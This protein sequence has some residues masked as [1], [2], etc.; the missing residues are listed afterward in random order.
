MKVKLLLQFLVFFSSFFMPYLLQAQ[1]D[2]TVIQAVSN[3]VSAN[4]NLTYTILVVN[5]GPASATNVNFTENLPPGTTFVSFTA[6]AGWN[7]VVP[8]VGVN[9]PVIATIP[10]LAPGVFQTFTLVVNVGSTVFTGQ[11]LSNIAVVSSPTPDPDQNN[12]QYPGF[13][14]VSVIPTFDIG[15]SNRISTT[16][17][18]GGKVICLVQVFNPAIGLQLGVSFADILPPGTS[19]VS[20]SAPVGWTIITPA[21]GSNGI[22]T[23]SKPTF[24]PDTVAAFILVVNV[25]VNV[26]AGT[27][28]SNTASVTSFTPDLNLN[29]NT[30]GSGVRVLSPLPADLSIIKTG[31]VTVT[32]GSNITYTITVRNNGPTNAE[33]V[34]LS[35]GLQSGSTFIS[36]TAPQGWAVSTPQPGI[37]GIITATIPM[38]ANG[39]TATFTLVVR[40]ADNLTGT[41]NNTA[42]ISSG[43]VDPNTGNNFSTSTAN[44]PGGTCSIT[45]P[46]NIVVTS[47]PGQCGAI[48]TFPFPSISGNCGTV[49]AIPASG[50]FFPAGTTTVRISTSTGSTCSFNIR[51]NETQPPVITTCPALAP[52]CGNS[53]GIYTIPRLV[54]TDNCGPAIINYTISGATNRSGN[55][56]NASGFFGIGTSTILWTVRDS[57]NN[58]TSCQTKVMVNNPVAVNIPDATALS[59]GVNINTVYTGYAPASKITLTAKA[60]GGTPPYS[61]SWSNGATTASINVSPASATSYRVTVTDSF[62]CKQVSAEKLVKVENVSCG[63][64]EGKVQVC[65]VPPG[66]FGVSYN[67]CVEA[68]VVASLLKAGS[69]LGSC[70]TSEDYSLSLKA[71][72]NPTYSYFT[73]DV[74]SN[75]LLDKITLNIYS[76]TGTL[77]ESRTVNANSKIQIGASYPTGTYLAEAVQGTKKTSLILIK[78]K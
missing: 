50:S 66:N 58:T 12:N 68:G 14:V 78:L 31:P 25:A 61:Y 40:A 75:N 23:A 64:K 2:L 47:A 27:I 46:A 55:G 4:R 8:A 54:A 24:A 36:L 38:L 73:V 18:I 13:S 45:C 60:S 15:L 72:P 59:T 39:A 48:V 11:S 53:S 9:A 16:V 52:L 76:I 26:P 41:L 6:L 30:S 65:I 1:A 29:N 34:S 77:V 71:V 10:S 43:N 7:I 33:N 21:V 74:I 32:T 42:S 56:D 17:N 67:S 3:N 51:V 44:N 62:G 35:D 5:N 57:S 70:S 49:T 22:I 19:F 69:H 20:L 28:I 37:S 63:T